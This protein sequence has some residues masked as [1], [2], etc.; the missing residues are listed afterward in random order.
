MAKKTTKWKETCER[1]F[2]FILGDPYKKTLGDLSE[3]H[4][5]PQS[6][7]IRA[8]IMSFSKL[9]RSLREKRIDDLYAKGVKK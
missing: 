6:D 2:S 4:G 7:I 3:N 9:N 1:G 8:A 5:S